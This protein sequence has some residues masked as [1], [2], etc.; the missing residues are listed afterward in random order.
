MT[1]YVSL[2]YKKVDTTNDLDFDERPYDA[3]VSLLASY[4]VTNPRS[5]VGYTRGVL[6]DASLVSFID[7]LISIVADRSEQYPFQ[8][9]KSWLLQDR[10]VLLEFRDSLKKCSQ[11]VTNNEYISDLSIAAASNNKAETERILKDEAFFEDDEVPD[12]DEWITDPGKIVDY[13]YDHEYDVAE[14]VEELYVGELYRFFEQL[15][16]IQ[17]GF[18]ISSTVEENDNLKAII[19]TAFHIIIPGV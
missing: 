1:R 16:M 8:V 10:S 18:S 15:I 9:A 17:S 2:P 5:V 7:L 4:N 6:I 3:L 11:R 19:N 13:L 12:F 14:P